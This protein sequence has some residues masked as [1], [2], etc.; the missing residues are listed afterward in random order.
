MREG[1]EISNLPFI[2][3]RTKRSCIFVIRLINIRTKNP[4]N[5]FKEWPLF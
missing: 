4:C 1:T 2:D 5:F 3:Y